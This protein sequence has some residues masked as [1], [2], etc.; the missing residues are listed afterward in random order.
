[1]THEV[2]FYPPI[3]YNYLILVKLLFKV[4]YVVVSFTQIFGTLPVHVYLFML[5][6]E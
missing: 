6:L 2:Y 4:T 1:M 3:Y 5:C